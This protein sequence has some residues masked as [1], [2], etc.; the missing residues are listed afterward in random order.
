[1]TL[2]AFKR[3]L[4]EC[5][6]LELH[7]IGTGELAGVCS[8]L[9]NVLGLT[10]RVSLLGAA[11]RDRVADAMGKSFMFVQHSLVASD[12]DREGTP[13]AV[14]EAQAAALPVVSTCHEGIPEVVVE[15]VTGYL[16]AER[17]VPGMARAIVRLAKD[18]ALAMH[19][20]L[21]ARAHIASSF[22]MDRHLAALSAALESAVNR[23][24]DAT[25]D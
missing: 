3:A 22:T 23:S 7:M 9:I 19:M 14:L 4:E 2:L 6:D 10:G 21:S 25:S 17:D 13:V 18:R 8:D 20:G 24:L 16:V 12:G 1:L 11:S 15:N 5:P